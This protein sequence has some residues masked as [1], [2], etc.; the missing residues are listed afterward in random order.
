M[1]A[2]KISLIPTQVMALWVW[3]SLSRSH[4]FQPKSWLSESDVR[5]QDLTYSNP[6]HDSLSLMFA[7][8]IWLI[9]TQ[10]MT[11]WVWYSLSDLT[12]SNPNHGSLSLIF[13]VKISLI[14]TKVMTLWVWWLAKAK[15]GC[16]EVN[17]PNPSHVPP[18]QICCQYLT[19]SNLGHVHLRLRF[20]LRSHFFQPKSWLS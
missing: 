12:Y 17:F 16:Q 8:K 13:A 18:K 9:P 3:C 5:C 20:P 11:L 2:V 14:P 1:F 10:V 7:V 6:S 4:L 15:V 19:Y